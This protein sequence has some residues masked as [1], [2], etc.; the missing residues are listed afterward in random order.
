M[1][2]ISLKIRLR[3]LAA[4]IPI[5]LLLVGWTA[6]TITASSAQA[7]DSMAV[8]VSGAGT[9]AAQTSNTVT[10]VPATG[11][12]TAS[13]LFVACTGTTSSPTT[14]TAPYLITQTGAATITGEVTSNTPGTDNATSVNNPCAPSAGSTYFNQVHAVY[15][16]NSVTVKLP[17]GQS[18][19]GG[20]ILTTD[21]TGSA[22]IAGGT[23]MV[24]AGSFGPVIGTGAL[25]GVTGTVERTSVVMQTSSSISV[26]SVYW[27]Q[28]QIP[29]LS[30]STIDVATTNSNN[31]ALTGYYTT[32]WQNGVQINSCFSP[33]SFT[34]TNGA[35]YQIA[36]SDYGSESFSHWS[37]GTTNM[38]HTV[39]VPSAST[40]ISLAAVYSP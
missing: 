9:I 34:V 10:F 40:T 4:T 18:I 3:Y 22:L 13:P 30:I 29:A 16:F 19:T 31:G 27:I 5:A 23:T 20:L 11:S 38:F 36:V 28:L 37:D 25:T 1:H 17:N 26:S 35:S 6:M 7:D 8:T 33:C 21:G 15:T 32:L 39:D 24:T 12:T 2:R 14:T